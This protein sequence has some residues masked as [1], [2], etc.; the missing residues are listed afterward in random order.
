MTRYLVQNIDL[1]VEAG[2]DEVLSVAKKRLLTLFSD[3][4]ILLLNIS[5][6]SVDAR[7]RDNIKFIWSVS[8]DVDCDRA[9]PRE[10]LL[11][12][13]IALAKSSA[14]HPEFGSEILTERPVIAGF[15]PCGMFCGLLLAEYGYRPIIIER[16][17]DVQSRASD[18]D[19]FLKN[20]VLNTESNIQFGAGGAGTFSDGK[21]V[22]RI[23][24]EKCAYVIE[25]LR[26]FGAPDDII[27]L[28][29]PHIGTDNLRRVVSNIHNEIISLGG[30]IH[31][32]TRLDG[33]NSELGRIRSVKTSKGTIPCGALILAIG[34]SARDTFDAVKQNGVLL[35]A[36]AF[37]VGVRIEH[38]QS[39]IDDA[40]YGVNRSALLPHGEYNLSHK[41]RT[42]RGVYT[43]CMCPGGTVMASSSEQNGIVTNGMSTYLRDGKNAN[44]AVAVSV[45]PDDFGNDPIGAIEY[46]RRLEMRAFDVGKGN[47]AAPCQT[48]GSFLSGKTNKYSRVMPTYM[49]GNVTMCDLH[50]VLP[51][52]VSSSLEEGLTA[53]DRQIV[54]F[55]VDD[56]VLTGVETRTS[57][58]V[59]IPR[60]DVFT[61]DGY[62]NLYP[63]GEGA[64]YAGGITSAAVDGI[65][66]ALSVMAKYRA[67]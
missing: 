63:A 44:S 13:G 15:G 66:C 65:N 33:L 2:A 11:S 17:S 5:K 25:Q 67:K 52:I 34:H 7:K 58:P 4:Q 21:L 16:G 28:A 51:Q 30:E 20:K 14:I 47:Y 6:R 41:C 57:S 45:L 64:G 22:T 39:D 26:K 55:A 24:D 19:N 1:P 48:V 29:K 50:G 62:I 53:F 61:A 3:K 10:K 49:D 59:R 40:M 32:N 23:N 60:S 12:R 43:F 56:A 42:G 9:I 54:G 8:A 27:Y 46:Q 18:V 36:K 31:Y 37:S 38:L 35:T